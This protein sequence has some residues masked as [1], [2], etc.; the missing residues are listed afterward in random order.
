MG[1]KRC[2]KGTYSD[3]KDAESCT[4]CPDGQTTMWPESKS[5]DDCYGKKRTILEIDLCLTFWDL[6]QMLKWTKNMFCKSV[7]EGCEPGE[8]WVSWLNRCEKCHFGELNNARWKQECSSRMHIV[9]S[10]PY[11][12]FPWQRSPWIDIPLDRDPLDRSLSGV[13]S[14]Q[15]VCV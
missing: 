15:E 6:R 7:L 12:G 11:G 8:E 2:D 14:V 9:H 3:V 5:A 13:I 4:A 10:L 1:C